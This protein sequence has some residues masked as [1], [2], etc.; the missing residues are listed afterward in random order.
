M[1]LW[2]LVAK[3]EKGPII[4]PTRNPLNVSR[5]ATNHG[6]IRADL[7]HSALPL[8]AAADPAKG[9]V[10]VYY[11]DVNG[12][13]HNAWTKDRGQT[14]TSGGAINAQITLG[15]NHT[16][17]AYCD[18]NYDEPRIVA[19]NMIESSLCD[20]YVEDGAWENDFVH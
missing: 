8:A 6:P 12:T 13:V 19:V 3:V 17:S 4:N 15:G 10:W 2:Y 14:W 11:T 1:L 18:P 9:K 20:A 7:N 16:M 5:G